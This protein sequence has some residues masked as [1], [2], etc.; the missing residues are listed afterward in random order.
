MKTNKIFSLLTVLVLGLAMVGLV[1]PVVAYWTDVD[2]DGYKSESDG[3]NPPY[4]CDDTNAAINPGA[5]EVC[6]DDVDNDCDGLIDGNDPDCQ[7]HI[8]EFATI[9]LPVASVLGLLFFFNHRKRRKE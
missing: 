2:G 5:D 4:D 8:P 9:A 1:T 7:Q 6:D 3:N